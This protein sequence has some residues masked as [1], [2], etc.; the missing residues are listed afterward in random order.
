MALHFG[1]LIAHIART[2]RLRAGSLVGSGTVSQRDA[3]A[4]YGCIA[5]R[6]AR[7]IL[8]SGSAATDYMAFGDTLRIEV[9]GPDG[10]SVFGAI[11]QRVAPLAAAG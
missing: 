1:Q 7:E 3:A 2:R 11:D 5:E 4:G 10:G 6:R 9:Q 8:E